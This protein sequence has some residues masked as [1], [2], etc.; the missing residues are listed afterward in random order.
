MGE[1]KAVAIGLSAV[2]K[3][4]LCILPVMCCAHVCQHVLT[5]HGQRRGSTEYSRVLTNEGGGGIRRKAERG[6]E[7]SVVALHGCVLEDGSL[8]RLNLVLHRLVRGVGQFERAQQLGELFELGVELVAIFTHH[9]IVA[10]TRVG[11]LLATRFD[12]RLVRGGKGGCTTRQT[13]R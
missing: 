8:Q 13:L 2:P 9:F 1:R 5:S 12:E 11:R 4:Q 6:A 7:T 10:L 3:P